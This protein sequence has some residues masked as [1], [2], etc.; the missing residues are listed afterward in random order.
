[1]QKRELVVVDSEKLAKK[2][3]KDLADTGT[4]VGV[5]SETTSLDQYSCDLVVFSFCYDK[6]KTIVSLPKYLPHFASNLKAKRCVFCNA[7]YDIPV[8]RRAGCELD[9]YA[10]VMVLDWLVDVNNSH[11]LKDCAKRYLGFDRKA[12]KDLFSYV[13]EG[14][15]KPVMYTMG[16]LFSVPKLRD[17]FYQY[18]GDDAADTYDVFYKTRDILKERGYWETYRKYD[19]PMIGILMRMHERG[20][21]IDR[22]FLEDVRIK[23]QKRIVKAEHVFKRMSNRPDINISST[24]QLAELLFGKKG[25][26]LPVIEETETGQPKL[27]KGVLETMADKGF[28]PA[29]VLLEHRN[30]KTM[31]GTFVEGL[32]GVMDN[33]DV[34]RTWFRMTSTGYGDEGGTVSGRL[35]S[36]EPNLQN[37]P[38]DKDKD[39]YRIRRSFIARTGFKLVVADYSMEELRLLAHYCQDETMLDAFRNGRD[40]HSITALNVFKLKC[41]ESEVKEKHGEERKKGKCFHPDTEV[42]TRRGW[43]KIGKLRRGEEIIQA[44]PEDGFVRLEWVV[45]LEV[46]SMR[47]SSNQIVHLRNEGIDLRVTPDHR[48]LGMTRDGNYFDIVPENLSKA[49]FWPNAGSLGA[50]GGGWEPSEDLL[51][52]AVATQADGS[53]AGRRI[54]FGFTRER[55]ISR[56]RKLLSCY[57]GGWSSRISSQGAT[58]FFIKWPLSSRIKDLLDSDK[59]LPWGWLNL[60][61]RRRELVLEEAKYWDSGTQPNWRMYS[62]CS[63]IR[64]NIDVLQAIASLNQRKTRISKL[65]T[66][67]TIRDRW[68]TRGGHLKARKYKYLRKVACLSVPST[69]VLVRDGGIPV[70]TGQTI[71]FGTVYG[72]GPK[73]L[74]IQM[75]CSEE[76]AENHLMGFFGIYTGIKPWMNG[77]ITEC[78]RVGYASTLAGRRRHL[79]D[80]NN[81]ANWI[82]GH[83]ERQAV[84]HVIQG[85]A[86]DVIKVAMIE[87]DE[88]RDWIHVLLQVHDEL[89]IEVKENK[90]DAAMKVIKRV[91]EHPTEVF[92]L[93]VP[94]I[95]DIK[96]ANTWEEAK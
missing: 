20:I 9:V 84:N 55:K 24:K 70:I 96:S 58:E 79:P 86:A 54:R 34:V 78:R 51:R 22:A 50:V 75:G 81:H 64:K 88:Y 89:V 74:S 71:N 27:D 33:K 66:S 38:K 17:R 31:L 28:E 11:G 18:S 72:V 52:L 63:F 10:D 8:F 32:L 40:L 45:P 29:S 65:G 36:R 60:S 85:S 30:A 76:E 47:H 57:E 46:F 87:L 13:P 4:V 14:K 7:A 16:E 21:K 61:Y 25:Y 77:T 2:I 91:M 43:V 3:Q 83:A 5:D 23:L 15:K 93:S 19:N 73:T 1:M 59:T 94:L 62:Y 53:Y 37:I 12:M 95:V 26:H 68:T 49:Y 48:M 67:L 92:K 44:I 56:M 82:R 80:I 42:L 90:V 41:K 69:Y 6:S 35:S 39:Q